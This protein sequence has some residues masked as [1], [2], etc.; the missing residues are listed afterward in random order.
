MEQRAEYGPWRERPRL[1]VVTEGAVTYSALPHAVLFS[2]LSDGEVRVYATVQSYAWGDDG[3]CTASQETIA[4]KI[5]K[6]TRTVRKLLKNLVERG[7][8]SERKTGHGQAKAYR[9]SSITTGQNRPVASGQN[10]PV[11]EPN[12]PKS[13]T[14]PAKNSQF[15]WPKSA[16][17]IEEYEV[18]K[19]KEEIPTTLVVAANA[20]T[21]PD[22]V[23]PKVK[24]ES[25]ATR[26]PADWT[27]TD[28]HF[29]AASKRG[30]DSARAEAEGEKFA[31]YHRAK[32]TR[33]LD[34]LAAWRTWLGNAVE[35]DKRRAPT[36]NGSARMFPG[37]ASAQK[38]KWSSQGTKTRYPVQTGGEF[39]DDR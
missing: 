9:C 21:A 14:Q 22:E 4:A 13:A 30:F 17:P 20:A 31:D 26:L 24:P 35:F 10:V 15:N 33:M 16:A 37:E 8:L 12:R 19:T 2:D 11:I 23:N 29:Q 28:A 34:W 7:Y 25:R 18:K 27:L 39:S 36:P 6:E 38:S 1:T 32:G 5:G 3:E